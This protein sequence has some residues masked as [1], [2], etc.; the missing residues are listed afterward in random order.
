MFHLAI[1][2][3]TPLSVSVISALAEIEVS[4]GRAFVDLESL[5]LF[6][7]ALEDGLET[8]TPDG[9]RFILGNARG[10]SSDW[11]WV[12]ESLRRA[13]DKIEYLLSVAG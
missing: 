8:I 12:V 10:H 11:R 2:G 13:V 5:V 7:G 1:D 4:E 9:D 3:E 6:S